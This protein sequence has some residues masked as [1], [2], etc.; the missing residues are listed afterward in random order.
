MEQRLSSQSLPKSEKEPCVVLQL[1]R[2]WRNHQDNSHAQKIPNVGLEHTRTPESATAPQQQRRVHEYSSTT[3]ESTNTKDRN[4]PGRPRQEQ[5]LSGNHATHKT[6]RTQVKPMYADCSWAAKQTQ[7]EQRR[8]LPMSLIQPARIKRATCVWPQTVEMNCAA[9]ALDDQQ[10]LAVEGS[11]KKKLPPPQTPSDTTL[12]VTPGQRTRNSQIRRAQ[13]VVSNFQ[14]RLA[15][16]SNGSI[17]CAHFSKLLNAGEQDKTRPQDPSSP[18]R[19]KMWAILPKA[20]WS[21]R[22]MHP[23]SS[24]ALLKKSTT[25]EYKEFVEMM[26]NLSGQ[27]S[28]NV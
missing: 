12:Q 18:L 8:E 17:I 2:W 28:R 9:R 25:T 14:V 1:P 6:I 24:Q 26:S 15:Q 13:D 11:K 3:E 16:E 20:P 5:K 21:D 27:T 23:L 19:G 10:Q 4:G 22:N 7:Q